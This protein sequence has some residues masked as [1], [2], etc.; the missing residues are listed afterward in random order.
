M[1]AMWLCEIYYDYA[2]NRTTHQLMG[3][4]FKIN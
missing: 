1:L 3:R 4:Q 2:E